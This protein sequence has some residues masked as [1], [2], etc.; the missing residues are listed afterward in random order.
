ML[1]K[2]RHWIVLVVALL[3]LLALP[4]ARPAALSQPPQRMVV[5]VHPSVKE[6]ALDIDELRAVFL[7]KRLQ[8]SGGLHVVPINQPPGT[9]SRAVFDTAILGW[10][11]HQIA[12]YW[13]DARIRFGMQPPQVVPGDATVVQVVRALPGSI[14]YVAADQ[15]GFGVRLIAR[16][17][18]GQVRTP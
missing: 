7:R 8:W 4:P 9:P 15:M 10:N 3:A 17:E 11:P 16:V 6:H 1:I 18:A 12:R 2:L 13:I 5:I 14:G